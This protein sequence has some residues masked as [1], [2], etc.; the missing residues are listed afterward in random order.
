MLQHLGF[1]V[2]LRIIRTTRNYLSIETTVTEI[3]LPE[4]TSV[5]YNQG[6]I[7]DIW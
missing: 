3:N 7:S 2:E 1:H 4:S 6:H 5:V